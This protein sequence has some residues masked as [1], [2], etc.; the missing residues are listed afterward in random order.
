M[1]RNMPD[2]IQYRVALIGKYDI[3][4]F[5]HQLHYEPLGADIAHLIAVLQLKG[6]DALQPGL[7]DGEYLRRTDIFAQQH[8]EARSSLRRCLAL[9]GYIYQRKRGSRG[10]QEPVSL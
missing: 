1:R 4:I 6:D 5:A 7:A 2:G 3:G 8:A 9:R 10:Y